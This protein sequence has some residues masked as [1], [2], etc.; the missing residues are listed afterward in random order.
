MTSRGW[1]AGG[2]QKLLKTDGTVL[3]FF[4]PQ[5]PQKKSRCRPA[6]PSRLWL[7]SP[8]TSCHLA[9]PQNRTRHNP[10]CSLRLFLSDSQLPSLLHL[11]FKQPRPPFALLGSRAVL[12]I[13]YLLTLLPSFV[14]MLRC[15]TS[16]PPLTGCWVC[17]AVF[18]PKGLVGFGSVCLGR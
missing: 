6:S 10:L 2:G 17:K 7:L 14:P 13:P 4:A 12:A 16:A 5:P 9:A 1:R 11:P 18:P 8:S 15:S 3:H